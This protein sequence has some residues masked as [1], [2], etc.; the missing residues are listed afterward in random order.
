M[1]LGSG[2]QLG[3]YKI[4]EPLGTGG[5]GEVY[6][7]R[8]TRHGRTVAIKLLAADIVADAE[9][10]D[11][12]LRDARAAA[13][14]SHPNIAALYEIGDDEGR[15]FLAFEFVPGAT[16]K[17]AI[18]GRALNPRRAVDL[19][20][21][22]ADALADAHAAGVVHRDIRPDNIIVTPKGSAK[23]L[24]FGLA[25]WTLGGAERKTAA[26]LE[27]EA[28]LE[29]AG[30]GATRGSIPYLSPEQALGQRV[31]DRTDIFSLGIVLF[32]MLTGRLPFNASAPAALA[33]QI[34]QA[35][36]P[37]VSALNPA[38]PRELDA[39]VAKALAKSPD[40]RYRSAAT[41]AAELRAVGAILDVRSAESE[42]PAVVP[43]HAPVR[44]PYRRW[45]VLALLLAALAAA[46]WW[47]RA[48]IE[49]VWRRSMGP[50]IKPAASESRRAAR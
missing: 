15:L 42:P 31:D 14:L 19:G 37:A 1:P 26:T 40:Q 17:T 28:T 27:T 33:R 38:V 3:P 5:M 30:V 34:A 29:T 50:G 6:R 41:V 48:S 35:P 22:I 20:I 13:A 44:R 24:D 4:L 36:A 32:E 2:S 46:G 39:I 7:A 47:Q 11:R 49:R 10:R 21:Q 23:I 12:F 45:I 18:A 16:L 43:L 25:A 8:D 9:R